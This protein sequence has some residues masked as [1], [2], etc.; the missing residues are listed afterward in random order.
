MYRM[1]LSQKC[2]QHFQYSDFFKCSNTWKITTPDNTPLSA[3]TYSAIKQMSQTILDPLVDNFGKVTLT[4][5]FCSAKL[6]SQIKK[7]AQ[8]TIT[9]S[10][11]QH[12]GYELNSRGNRI[13]K[14]D[15]FACDFIIPKE[16]MR[17]VSRWLIQNCDFD[18]LYFY[19]DTRPIHVSIAP[20]NHRQIV[21]MKPLASGKYIPRVVKEENF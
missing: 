1:E 6:A 16:S 10:L 4:Y 21:I 19:D 13:C 9:P 17:K 8:P 18:R 3:D 20:E 5:G 7:N 12:A 14:R 2:S 15:G 11:D